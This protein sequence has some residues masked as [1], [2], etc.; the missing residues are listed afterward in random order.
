ME[1]EGLI[2]A[3]DSV[4]YRENGRRTLQIRCTCGQFHRVGWNGEDVVEMPCG[5]WISVPEW[6]GGRTSY[7]ALG[8]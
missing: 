8:E 2:M 4:T 3:V 1:V 6:C 5:A 7:K